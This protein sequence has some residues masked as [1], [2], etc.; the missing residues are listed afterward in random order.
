M[1][2]CTSASG[3][4][5]VAAWLA[6]RPSVPPQGTDGGFQSY[7]QAFF[8]VAGGLWTSTNVEFAVVMRL[9]TM[10]CA[11]VAI[12]RAPLPSCPPSSIDPQWPR[13]SSGS[14]P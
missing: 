3:I 6:V 1:M 13:T 10:G 4:A 9:L 2:L 12:A 5:V 14:A 7:V 8:A 11:L